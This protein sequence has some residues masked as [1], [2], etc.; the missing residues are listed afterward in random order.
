MSAI[1]GASNTIL[2]AVRVI[3][4]FLFDERVGE[5]LGSCHGRGS[6]RHARTL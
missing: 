5:M 1:A 4:F 6:V 3:N 2:R